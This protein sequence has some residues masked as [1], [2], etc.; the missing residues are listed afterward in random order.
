M[1]YQLPEI[2]FI[3]LLE[4]IILLKKVK[5]VMVEDNKFIQMDNKEFSLIKE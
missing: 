1:G 4:Q 5:L 2:Q 3:K